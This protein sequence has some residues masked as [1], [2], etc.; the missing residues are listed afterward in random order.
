MFKKLVFLLILLITP[1]C[2]ATTYYID[3]DA[4][5]DANAGTATGTA[6]QK[7]PG[8]A[9][10]AGDYAHSAGDVFVFKGGETWPASC[11]RM[12]ITY[13]G[14]ADSDDVYMGGQR[15]GETGSESCNG[16]SPWGSGYPVF[17]GEEAG[18]FSSGLVY[19]YNDIDY[20]TV[21]GL[22][23]IRSGH[24]NGSGQ[25]ILYYGGSYLTIKHCWLEPDS[26][27]AWAYSTSSG[28]YTEIYFHDN[29]IQK[30]GRVH[31]SAGNARLTDVRLYNNIMYGGYDYD[32]VAYHSDGFMIGGSGDSDYAIKGLAI[33]NNQFRGRWERYATAQVYLNG[34][35][36]YQY[37]YTGGS[38]EPTVGQVL[39]GNTSG[40]LGKVWSGYTNAGG[41]AG[42]GTGL[43][44]LSSPYFI[45]G[46]TFSETAGYGGQLV[47]TMA[48]DDTYTSKKSTSGTKI[49]NNLFV[50]E[51]T[52][53]KTLSPAML[54]VA[55]GHDDLEVFNNT[56]DA[57][58]NTVLKP[59]HAM[60][61]GPFVDNIVVKNN[62]IA[63]T[64]NGITFS[65]SPTITIDYNMYKTVGDTNLIWDVT[66]VVRYTTIASAQGAG[67]EANGLIDDPEFT[68]LPDG[69]E[70]S[71]DWSLQG[72]SPAIGIGEDLSSFFTIYDSVPALVTDWNT[73]AYMEDY[74]VLMPLDDLPPALDPTIA[75]LSGTSFTETQIAAG[76]QTTTGTLSGD[77]LVATFGDDNAITTAFI[78]GFDGTLAGAGSWDDEMTIV[79]GNVV[80]DSDTQ[81]TVTLPATAGYDVTQTEEVTLTVPATSLTISTG[82]LVATPNLIVSVVTTSTPQSGLGRGGASSPAYEFGAGLAIEV[83]P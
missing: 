24:V 37:S 52:S 22:K 15:C 49:Y 31:V 23:I 29:I 56:L 82:S 83:K 68:T 63:G 70:D 53:G 59:S 39:I 32:P 60:F 28:E 36:Y 54:Y 73:V 8:M 14:N 12:R 38:H 46:E 27:N 57:R 26:I 61:F 71:G 17:D 1:P 45:N 9:S 74:T 64:N 44:N 21:D 41:W 34:L 76:G 13:S 33:Y 5:S 19:K 47:G 69:S 6:W 42:A 77:T 40:A 11:F 81:F 75:V 58:S 20:V 51:N 78:A 79:H 25:G 4:G 67:Y 50:T 62:V 80:R 55:A 35:P 66:G 65:G 48:S 3:Y 10:F 30:A 7:A 18:L 43:I 16:G 72:G 2:W